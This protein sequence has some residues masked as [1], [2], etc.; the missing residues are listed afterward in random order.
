MVYVFEGPRNSGKT[1][2][3]K[4]V[5]AKYNIP[6]FQFEFS[7]YFKRLQ[8]QSQHSKEAHAFALG[9]ELMLMQIARDLHTGF[10]D[11]PKSFIHDR[12]ILSVLSWGLLEGRI[13][14]ED[15]KSQAA[16]IGDMFLLNNIRIIL[17]LG[18]NPDQSE[19]KKDQWDHFDGGTLEF[20]CYV[21]VVEIMEKMGIAKVWWFDNTFDQKSL[22]NISGLFEHIIFE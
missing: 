7:E 3:S 11:D 1:F 22:D 13:T 12:G 16:I 2:L 15:V 18:K 4:Y 6:R 17:I 21:K 8:I 20:E 10:D 14:E 5:S 19:R 9:K